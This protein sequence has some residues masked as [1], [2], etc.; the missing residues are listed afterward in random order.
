MKVLNSIKINQEFAEQKEYEEYE[1]FI[2]EL[3]IIEKEESIR[4]NYSPKLENSLKELLKKIEKSSTSHLSRYSSEYMKIFNRLSIN[5]FC[6]IIN[7]LD[8]NYPG[9]SFHY[10]M[11]SR[12]NKNEQSIEEDLEIKNTFLRN[13][14]NNKQIVSDDE[15]LVFYQRIYQIKNKGLL[16]YLFAP[17]RRRLIA[18]LFEEVQEDEATKE[19]KE[20]LRDNLVDHHFQDW[21]KGKLTNLELQNLEVYKYQYLFEIEEKAQAKKRNQALITYVPKFIEEDKFISI[22]NTLINEIEKEE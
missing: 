3:K 6:N 16:K 1:N 22:I 8:I 15:N 18:G 11:E 20:A 12:H 5:H 9:L 7:Y 4:L 10:V 14:I 17:M 21:L 19:E 2:N 13:T